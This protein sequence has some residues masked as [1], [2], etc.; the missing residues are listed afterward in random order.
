MGEKNDGKSVKFK[1][2][3]PIKVTYSYYFSSIIDKSSY[4]IFYLSPAIK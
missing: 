3:A 4:F 1:H 2:I